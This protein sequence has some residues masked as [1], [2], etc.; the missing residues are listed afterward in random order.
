MAPSAR[1]PVP[2]AEWSA[3]APGV[4]RLANGHQTRKYDVQ[5]QGKQVSFFPFFPSLLSFGFVALTFFL[6]NQAL[7]CAFLPIRQISDRVEELLPREFSAFVAG[8][9]QFF[10]HFVLASQFALANALVLVEVVRDVYIFSSASFCSSIC[11]GGLL[12]A[13]SISHSFSYGFLFFF[14]AFCARKTFW[15]SNGAS[16]RAAGHKILI[17]FILFLDIFSSNSR[18]RFNLT[19]LPLEQFY[20]PEILRTVYET[21]GCGSGS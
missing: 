8:R 21:E 5:V 15:P 4:P 11:P 16:E 3:K 1:R 14:C 20:L 9:A 18:V 10:K 2:S 13:A 17:S 12:T 19:L 7:P 6:P